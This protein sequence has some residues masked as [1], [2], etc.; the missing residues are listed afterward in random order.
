MDG[1]WGYYAKWN[2]SNG[3]RQISYDF[4]HVWNIKQANEQ[5]TLSK[6]KHVETE[7]SVEVTSK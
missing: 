5:P 6:N 4:S 3:K 2:K 1:S 7:N